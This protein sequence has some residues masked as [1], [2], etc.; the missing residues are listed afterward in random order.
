M[1]RN[2]DDLI[3]NSQKFFDEDFFKEMNSN[4][5]EENSSSFAIQPKD[6][7]KYN[8]VEESSTKLE[9][10]INFYEIRCKNCYTIPVIKIDTNEN[11]P[12]IIA[13][14]ECEKNKKID[15]ITFLNNY[16]FKFSNVLC[17]NCEKT[18]TLYDYDV[19]N[20]FCKNCF[21]ESNKIMNID[22]FD[23]TCSEHLEKFKSYCRKCCKNLCKECEIE[24]EDLHLNHDKIDI[25]N[26][27][28]PDINNI[29]HNIE[30]VQKKFKFKKNIFS[31]M[32]SVFKQNYNGEDKMELLKELK[33][34]FERNK[35][36]NRIIL[37]MMD[38]TY[39]CYDDQ[40]KCNSLTYSG[41]INLVNVTNFN[42]NITKLDCN[43]EHIPLKKRYNICKNFILHDYLLNRPVIEL[44][45]EKN[46]D[47]LKEVPP[48]MMDDRPN[49]E[50]KPINCIEKLI[51]TDIL[52]CGKDNGTICF[53]EPFI[54]SLCLKIKAHDGE[55]LYLKQ[56]KNKN[57]CSC[58]DD[59]C[60]KIWEVKNTV[61]KFYAEHLYTLENIHNDKINKVIEL[62]DSQYFASCSSDLYIK[63][64]DMNSNENKY[65]IL[66]G[67]NVVCIESTKNYL[68]GGCENG[69][70]IFYNKDNIDNEEFKIDDIFINSCDSILNL[71][72]KK[73]LVGTKLGELKIIDLAF[74][75]VISSFNAHEGPINCLIINDDGSVF[76]TGED[77]YVNRWNIYTENKLI[78]FQTRHIEPVL[79]VKNLKTGFLATCSRD[80]YALIYKY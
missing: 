20:F 22:E 45:E 78:S 44:I 48:S 60:I 38:L 5:H 46:Y 37:F 24:E 8:L 75:N 47:F 51:N 59:C 28:I 69:N 43:D 3:E 4:I 64:F 80:G 40:Q 63:I 52:A 53:Y 42:Y 6:D 49:P 1:E 25:D 14:C 55:V 12:Q 65:S 79:Q 16:N 70:L 29:K 17:H 73:I 26:I 77:E 34:I 19:K 7:I 72:N 21:N 76:S 2:L 67:N 58:S 66:V 71:D 18:A 68:I 15:L 35:Y 56:F 27:F 31:Q 32:Y 54:Y 23:C 62:F 9:D 33:N 41:I 11:E 39:K 57:L 50:V 13:N 10:N 61:Y 36:L 30:R 74:R